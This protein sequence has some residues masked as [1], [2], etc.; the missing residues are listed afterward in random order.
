MMAGSDSHNSAMRTPRC[1]ARRTR[2]TSGSLPM[3][4]NVPMSAPAENARSACDDH[5]LDRGILAQRFR[6]VGQ[7]L[8]QLVVQGVELVFALHPHQRYLGGDSFYFDQI[9]N[10]DVRFHG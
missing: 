9:G 5:D 6:R 3:A 1:V 7:A 8:D 10:H 4:S 2:L